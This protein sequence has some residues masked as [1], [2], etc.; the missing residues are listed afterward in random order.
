MSSAEEAMEMAICSLNNAVECWKQSE[1]YWNNGRERAYYNAFKGGIFALERA[2]EHI[3]KAKDE[4]TV[5][6]T[7]IGADLYYEHEAND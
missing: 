6:A 7:E 5:E 1:C 4:M 2:I 3:T